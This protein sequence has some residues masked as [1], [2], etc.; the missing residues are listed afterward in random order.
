MSGARRSMSTNAPSTFTSG[1]C[2]RPS[3]T[4]MPKTSSARY[5]GR[6]TP[7]GKSSSDCRLRVVYRAALR[8][9]LL[10]DEDE[11]AHG[12]AFPDQRQFVGLGVEGNRLRMVAAGGLGDGFAQGRLDEIE[13]GRA[14]AYHGDR[15]RIDQG[16]QATKAEAKRLAGLAEGFALRSVVVA[17]GSGQ[18]QDF[19]IGNVGDGFIVFAGLA[20]VAPDGVVAGIGFDAAAPAAA[21]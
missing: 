6:V 13:G 1:A 5:A 20:G 12:A 8:E 3:M 11:R 9:N 21:A 14:D 2:A 17:G 18:R 7:S 15:S 19:G 4:A 16:K 10:I